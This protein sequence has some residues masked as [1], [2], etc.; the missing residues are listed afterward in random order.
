M[1]IILNFSISPAAMLWGLLDVINACVLGDPVSGG[2]H[3]RS[4]M[5]ATGTVAK[6]NDQFLA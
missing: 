2:A 5:T 3:G 1:I 6:S 4:S